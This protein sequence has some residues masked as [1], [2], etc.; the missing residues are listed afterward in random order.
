[1]GKGQQPIEGMPLVQRHSRGLG[2][3]SLGR[4]KCVECKPQNYPHLESRCLMRTDTPEMYWGKH[5]WMDW[6]S[7][8]RSWKGK[9]S[10]QMTHLTLGKE[11]ERGPGRKSLRSAQSWENLSQANRGSPSGVAHWG[12]NG[13]M[14]APLPCPVTGRV[15]SCLET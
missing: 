12:R 7:V 11:G 6:G 5:L 10:E 3:N 8:S 15:L 2:H 13:F 14:L 1:M 4:L 9:L